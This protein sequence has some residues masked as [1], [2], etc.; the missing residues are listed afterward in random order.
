MTITDEDYN[1]YFMQR[2][3]S[4]PRLRVPPSNKISGQYIRR[5]QVVDFMLF[6]S[7]Y[8]KQLPLQLTK[9]LEPGL[10]FSEIM[11]IIKGST[12]TKDSLDSLSRNEY[13]AFS[14]RKAPAFSREQRVDVYELYIRYERLK[15]NNQDKDDID[16]VVSILRYLKANH[17]SP[18]SVE[19]WLEE[20]R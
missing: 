1:R 9:S 20:I 15:H 12:S 11:G 13:L 16:R 4:L 5:P 10:V 19:G 6:R 2:D 17:G 18:N 3:S 7:E 8:W 14:H